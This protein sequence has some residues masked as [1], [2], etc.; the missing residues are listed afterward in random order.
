MKS[1]SGPRPTEKIK[2]EHW[3][4][5]AHEKCN[6]EFVQR[7]TFNICQFNVQ[8]LPGLKNTEYSE[9]K[10][11]EKEKEG[12]GEAQWNTRKTTVHDMNSIC[13]LPE[14]NVNF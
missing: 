10:R 4:F 1:E 8:P 7:K 6:F 3:K 11:D 5:T 12:E 13:T 14:I 2:T 9:R